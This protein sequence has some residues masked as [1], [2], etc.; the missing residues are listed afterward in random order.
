MTSTVAVVIPYYENQRG[1]NLLLDALGRQTAPPARVLVVDDG[2][3]TAPAVTG[4]R[5]TVLRQ[6]DLG[7][8][9]AAARNLGVRHADA[10]VIA[11][12]DAD[13]LPERDYLAHVVRAMDEGAELVVGRRKHADFTALSPTRI[14]QWLG[15]DRGHDNPAP[16]RLPDPAWLA[17]GYRQTADLRSA[18]DRSYRFAISAVLST[19]RHLWERVDGFDESFSEYGGE[20]WE[21][22]HRCWLA[23]A[24]FA[25]DPDAVAWH[26][27]P[28]QA[29]RAVGGGRSRQHP[30]NREI[31]HLARLIPD[32]QL[33]P[34]GLIWPVP[35]I[36]VELSDAGAD[37]AVV[38]L[39]CADLLRSPDVRIWL[40]GG[41][42]LRSGAWPQTD[43]RVTAGP[44]PEAVIAGA[45]WRVRARAGIRLHGR[46]LDDL[47]QPG[48]AAGY[49]PLLQV[50]AT[51][52][53]ARGLPVADEG[54]PSWLGWQRESVAL[55]AVW[56]WGA[57]WG[58]PR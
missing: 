29:E 58:E 55:E 16:V 33:R 43:Q 47:C 21:F 26:D 23:G 9:A 35:R 6:P 46:S 18:D 54:H 41:A 56:G 49:G 4:P 19:T 36:A 57:S 38:V 1:L 2:S 40:S 39:T 22:A 5:T 34:G 24:E 8:R 7:F 12:L 27:G 53:A 20:D 51:R 31:G 42:A 28:D 32:P 17:E 10:D 3:A 44:V 30:K 52:G 14:S 50:I 25:H 48:A 11:F 15:G 13:M 45:P 37:D